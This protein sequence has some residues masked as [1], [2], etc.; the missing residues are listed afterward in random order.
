MAEGLLRSNGACDHGPINLGRY[1]PILQAMIGGIFSS[2]KR[3]RSG[4]ASEGPLRKFFL[5]YAQHPGM[6]ALLMALDLA[7]PRAVE[8]LVGRTST[9]GWRTSLNSVSRNNA[10]ALYRYLAK[11]DGGAQWVEA[12][13]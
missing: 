10:E 2:G 5:G 4:L 3:R 12:E 13:L 6:D 7:C 8:K 9:G 1:Y 11:G